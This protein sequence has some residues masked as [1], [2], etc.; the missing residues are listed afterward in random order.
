MNKA[1]QLNINRIDFEINTLLNVC[2]N[3]DIFMLPH[4]VPVYEKVNLNKL[5]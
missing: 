2:E 5:V 3:Y 1:L 4:E